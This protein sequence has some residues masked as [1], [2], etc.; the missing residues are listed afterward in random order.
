M[1]PIVQIRRFNRAVTQQVGA[2]RDDYLGRNRP[3]AECRLLFEIGTAGAEVRDLRAR[4]DLDSGYVSRM[5]RRLER[6]GLIR[7][8]K[9]E[10][11]A[12]VRRVTLT[13]AGRR[14]LAV[15]DRLSDDAARRLLGRLSTP[16]RTNLVA[17][18]ATVERLLTAAAVELDI[19]DPRGPDA[20]FCLESYFEELRRRFERGFDP[21]RSIPAQPEHFTP[22]AGY[23]VIARLHGAPVGC[24]GMKVHADG[25][26]WGELKRMWVAPAARGLGIGR[27]LLDYLEALARRRRLSAVRLETNKALKEAQSLYRGARYREVP[28]FNDEPYAHHWFEK[29]LRNIVPVSD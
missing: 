27:R 9:G 2:L 18:M 7:T 5:L 13:A 17:G 23:F 19:V 22:P 14:E 10:R 6:D 8:A 28:P 4:L 29:R 20:R 11:D 1:G 21:G 16:Q 12:R 26:G 15:L 25:A 24:G 3:L